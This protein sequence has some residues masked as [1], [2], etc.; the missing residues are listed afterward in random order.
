[1]SRIIKLV[2]VASL[3]IN[4]TFGL[5]AWDVSQLPVFQGDIT[6]VEF[7]VVGEATEGQIIEVEGVLY[8]LPKE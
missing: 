6:K 1:M 8:I 5:W 4:L 7:K 2:A 3:L